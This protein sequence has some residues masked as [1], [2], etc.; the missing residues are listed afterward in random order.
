MSISK[1]YLIGYW[2]LNGILKDKNLVRAFENTARENFVLP[3]YREDAYLDE[4][5]PLVSGQTISQPTTVAIMTQALEPKPGQK[6]LEIGSGSGYQAAILSKIVGEKGRI[7]TVERISSLVK[8]ARKNLKSYGNVSV[9]HADGTRGYVQKAPYD[10][11]I[12]TA[13]AANLPEQIFSQ[14]KEKGIMVI[15]IEDHLFKIT[16]IGKKPKMEDLG[17]FAFV[18]LIPGAVEF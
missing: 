3:E 16:K 5:L 6:I 12:V 9:V 13:T 11:I 4:P 2:T 7:F 17:L 14:M 1:E 8:F 18:P 15:P 10:R